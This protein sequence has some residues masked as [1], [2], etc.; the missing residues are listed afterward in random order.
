M[1]GVDRNLGN[2]EMN[3]GRNFNTYINCIMSHFMFNSRIIELWWIRY[4]ENEG[5]FKT[6]AIK[7]VFLIV[8]LP[9]KCK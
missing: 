6:R 9:T 3:K 1:G 7:Q 5:R 4:S 2:V 8:H